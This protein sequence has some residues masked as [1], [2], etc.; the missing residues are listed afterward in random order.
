MVWFWEKNIAIENI[1]S[2]HID[3]IKFDYTFSIVTEVT[4]DFFP[5]QQ[6]FI[7]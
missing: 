5:V 3:I 1:K 4:T 7:K 6:M 2:N